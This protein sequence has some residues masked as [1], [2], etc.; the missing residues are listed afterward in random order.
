M[1]ESLEKFDGMVET[2]TH[3]KEKGYSLG[4]AS[5]ADMIKIE[6]AVN[7]V[8]AAIAANMSCIAIASSF[9]KAELM[10]AG[11]YEVCHV[12]KDIVAYL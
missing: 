9:T 5:S 2:L 1:D 7:G 3:L 4:L 8:Q 6:D 11:A 12:T 10:D